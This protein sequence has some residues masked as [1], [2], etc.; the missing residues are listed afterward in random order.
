MYPPRYRRRRGTA[1]I[2]GL[3]VII[4]FILV[5]T[6]VRY[7]GQLSN[8]SL[9]TR[10]AARNCAFQIALTGC[11]SVPV[12]CDFS[13]ENSSSAEQQEATSSVT[14]TAQDAEE[15][16]FNKDILDILTEAVELD[17]FK[18]ARVEAPAEIT[19]PELIGGDT[20]DLSQGMTLPCNPT[21]ETLG[22]KFLNLFKGI[23]G[24]VF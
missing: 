10:A 19:Q 13:E 8:R 16:D 17:L 5:W 6:G 2:E 15:D 22:D 21:R 18:R 9:S 20:V 12:G 23:F 7:V 3:I 11:E 4:F 1:S 24:Q 14:R